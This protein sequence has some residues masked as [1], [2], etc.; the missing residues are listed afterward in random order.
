MFLIRK[1]L[2]KEELEILE[3]FTISYSIYKNNFLTYFLLSM[4]CGMPLILS[5]IYFPVASVDPTSFEN[6]E[7]LGKWFL[8]D[9]GG[10]FYI[11]IFLSIFL[12]VL[13]T[14]AIALVTESMIYKRKIQT[15]I[16]LRNSLSFLIPAFFTSIIIYIATILGLLFFI[17][18]G[19]ILFILFS[20]TL[21]ICALRH[22]WGIRALKH[23]IM[24]IKRRFIKSFIIIVFIFIFQNTILLT[25]MGSE[26]N[27]REGLLSFFVSNILYYLFNGYFK[28]LL[29][30]FFLNLD[31]L[32]SDNFFDIIV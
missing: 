15:S 18:P 14:V 31:Y 17:I 30:L 16:A 12:D 25:F 20:F 23:S 32:N 9:S 10:G 3:L 19:I 4:L 7:S 13:L 5:T 21:N 26:I 29:T 8:K 11:N 27:T 22:S 24:L 28:V 2:A 1:R 6:L